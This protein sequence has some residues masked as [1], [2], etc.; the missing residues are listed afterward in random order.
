MVLALQEV[1]EEFLVGLLEQA[2]NIIKDLLEEDE[3]LSDRTVLSVQNII[4]FLGFC[5]HNTYFS[6]QNKFYEEVEGVAMGSPVGPIIANLYMEH[7]R[8]RLY[9]LPLTPQVL[10]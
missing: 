1:G 2:L 6:F 3:K 8:V 4:E 5:L 7:L 10:A 9:S